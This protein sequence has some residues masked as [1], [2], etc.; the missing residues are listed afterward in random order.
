[1]EGGGLIHVRV[2]VGELGVGILIVFLYVL[3]S[4]GL[5]CPSVF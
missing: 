3:L 2:W 1:M 4:F 5:S